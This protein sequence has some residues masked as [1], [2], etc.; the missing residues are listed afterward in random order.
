MNNVTRRRARILSVLVGL[1]LATAAHAAA[2][3]AD[4][5]R[6]RGPNGS[7]VAAAAN[8]PARFGEKDFNWR[9]ALPG[10]GHSSPAVVGGKVFVTCADQETAKRSVI[11]LDLATGKQLWRRD[12][13]VT[14]LK[15][16]KDNALAASTPAVDAE[17]VYATFVSPE[18]YKVLAYDH[19]GS[20]VWSYDMGPWQSEHGAGCSPVVHEGMLIVPND[21]TGPTASLVALDA[22][23]GAVR[24]KTPRKP[25]LTAAATPCVFKPKNGPAQI[26]LSCTASGLT[27]I[28]PQTGKQNWQVGFPSPTASKLRSVG[29]PV[30]TDTLVV[31]TAGQGGADRSGAVVQP[32]P[33]D[34]TKPPKVVA[35]LPAG[36]A[37]TYVPTPVIVGDL[38]FLWGDSATVTCVKAATGEPVWQQAL[39]KTGAA[40]LEFYSSPVVAGDKL[41]NVSKDGEVIC[42][43][44]GDKFELLGRSALGEKCHSTI[45]VAGNALLIRTTG[46]LVSVGK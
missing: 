24:W 17:R 31:G 27:S 35:K 19:S 6:F 8:T 18:S 40:P 46:H 14:G 11:A 29:S 38:M 25:G 37:Y 22:K 30:A 12:A 1:S 43:R 9:V 10:Y 34:P 3:D 42:L 36:R 20:E 5:G 26:I 15:Q 16:H 2:P 33:A 28:D 32:D 21:Q 45:A 39:P 44:A 7:G 41:Y 13:D 4:W 23:T